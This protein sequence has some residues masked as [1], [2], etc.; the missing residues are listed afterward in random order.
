MRLLGVLPALTGSDQA[1]R[2]F[3]ILAVTLTADE[4]PSVIDVRWTPFVLTQKRQ[5]V[6]PHQDLAWKA[7]TAASA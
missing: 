7:R 5:H 3:P 4:P 6:A 1:H 2:D